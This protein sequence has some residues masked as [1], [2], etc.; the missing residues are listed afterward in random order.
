VPQEAQAGISQEI[1]TSCF[2]RLPCRPALGHVRHAAERVKAA[3]AEKHVAVVS[4]SPSIWLVGTTPNYPLLQVM[5]RE[6]GG[7]LAS[8]PQNRLET[9]C[10]DPFNSQHGQFCRLNRYLVQSANPKKRRESRIIHLY[11]LS[12]TQL[13]APPANPYCGDIHIV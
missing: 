9:K 4:G 1:V 11:L 8:Q 5:R 12:I 7:F 2:R 13:M 10:E 6:S 3:F